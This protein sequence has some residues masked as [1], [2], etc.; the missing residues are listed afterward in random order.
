MLYLYILKLRVY[1][2]F[3]S[4]KEIPEKPGDVL[5]HKQVQDE[6]SVVRSAVILPLL[7][8]YVVAVI[9]E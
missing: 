7:H 8:V 9:V 6:S 4:V 3:A 1:H 2:D 5:S